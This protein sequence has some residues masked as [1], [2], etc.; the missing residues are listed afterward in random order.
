[1]TLR[2]GLL[3]GLLAYMTLDLSLPTMPGAFVFEPGDSVET[4]RINR[5]RGAEVVFLPQ[6]AL[7]VVSRPSLEAVTD[8]IPETLP[9][10]P[11]AHRVAHRL[12]RAAL[13]T[14]RP[15]EDPH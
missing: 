5:S 14:P 12:P 6:P 7:L 1:V 3:I 10:A 13:D 11:A 9:A 8:R 15:S 2:R 4:I